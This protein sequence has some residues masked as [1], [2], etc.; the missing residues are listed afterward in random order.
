MWAHAGMHMGAFVT[1]SIFSTMMMKGVVD[2]VSGMVFGTAW[3]G[4][5]HAA[6]L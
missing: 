1:Y 5:A 2:V 6:I 4:T 3:H